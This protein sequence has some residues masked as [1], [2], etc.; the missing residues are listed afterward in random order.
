METEAHESSDGPTT[1]IE[2]DTIIFT[3]T[4]RTQPQRTIIEGSGSGGTADEL[5]SGRVTSFS[6]TN[7]EHE[8]ERT[9]DSL[10]PVN[11]HP[12]ADGT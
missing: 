7:F 1:D 12:Q 11:T 5:E 6:L 2:L 3:D 10:M 4:N 8:R 9:G